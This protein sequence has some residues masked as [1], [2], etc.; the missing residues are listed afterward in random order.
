MSILVPS[1]ETTANDLAVQAWADVLRAAIS[2]IPKDQRNA[3]LAQ[4]RDLFEHDNAPKR[5]SEL[6]TN[7]YLIYKREPHTKRG[8]LDVVAELGLDKAQDA[9]P[10]RYALN[11]LHDRRVLRRVGYGKYQLENGDLVDGPP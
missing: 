6:L 9:Q 8:A 2:A 1:S 3:V 7:I 5:G 10:V 4:V 11:Y